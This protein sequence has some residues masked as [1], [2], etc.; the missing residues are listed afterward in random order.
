MS[1]KSRNTFV[2][3]ILTFG[4]LGGLFYYPSVNAP[5]K[6]V[7]DENAGEVSVPCLVPNMKLVRHDHSKLD[8]IINGSSI[9][10]PG[11]VGVDGSC[12]RALHTHDDEGG[13]GIIHIEAQDSNPYTLGD[14][15][16]VWGRVLNRN[17]I[18]DFKVEEGYELLMTLNGVPSNEFENLVLQDKQEIKLEYRAKEGVISATGTS[19]NTSTNT[20]NTATSTNLEI[21][22]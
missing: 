3:I 9:E 1:K 21:G 14:F 20:V 6:N 19:I 18:M 8:V 5:L 11:G 2:V 16:S 4:I 15:F 7:R 12:H 22:N 17:Q 10:I 13:P